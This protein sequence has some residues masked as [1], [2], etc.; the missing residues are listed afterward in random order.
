MAGL[1][2]SLSPGYRSVF[3]CFPE[4]G[5]CRAFLDV[6]RAEGHEAIGL[7]HDTPHLRAAI[8]EL[9]DHLARL[10]A[11][12]LC[13]HGYKADLLGLPAARR[14][15]VPVVAVSRGW[16]GASFKVRLYETLDRLCLRWMDRVVCVS[17][18]QAVKVFRTGVPAGRVVVIRNAVRAE[19]FAGISLAGHAR[20]QDF[21]P[22]PRR[23]IVGAAGRLSPEKG[24]DLLVRAAQP[25]VRAD[26]SL[27]FILFGDGPLR[28]K[29]AGRIAAAGLDRQFILAGFRADLDA[30]LPFLDLLVLPSYTEGLPNVVLEASAAGVPVVATAVGGTPEVVEDGVTGYLVPPGN[31]TALRD[32][33]ADALASEARRKAMGLRGRKWVREHFSFAAQA[34]Q[35]H[36]FFDDLLAPAR[37]PRHTRRCEVSC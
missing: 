29:L 32:R 9:A 10:E 19:R 24:F 23:R 13:C 34:R 11:D 28:G 26:P 2:R 36:E 27:G 17:R 14:Q 1:A 35:Y 16:T 3:L 12:V 7:N 22:E 15:G 6:V 21:F 20:L 4:G 33:I 30:L 8:A 18:G 37:S 31:V 25:L 5:R